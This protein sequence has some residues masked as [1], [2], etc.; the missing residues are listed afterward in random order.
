M[1]ESEVHGW[2]IVLAVQRA[3][4][5]SLGAISKRLAHLGLSPGEIN[6]L[7]NL[8]AAAEPVAVSRLSRAVG[9]PAS[10]M[11]SIL[12]RLAGRGLI[13]RRTPESNR[14]S[15]VIELSDPGRSVADEVRAAFG[16]IEAELV[17][18]FTATQVDQLRSLLELLARPS[19]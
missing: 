13:T 6:A 17:V 18:G 14:R 10:T 8:G 15:V 3:A 19:R 9:T 1:T 2:S 16:E 11:T 12:D 4:H 5:V 7:A